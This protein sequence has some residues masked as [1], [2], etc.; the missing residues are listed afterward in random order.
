VAP[1]PMA[2]VAIGI[3]LPMASHV[4]IGK[5]R[6]AEEMSA[7]GG[8]PTATSDCHRQSLCRWLSRLCRWLPAIGKQ[9]GSGSGGSLLIWSLVGT[10]PRELCH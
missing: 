3:A 1:L 9:A 8:L 6:F 2:D 10:P 7:D 4:A 5:L